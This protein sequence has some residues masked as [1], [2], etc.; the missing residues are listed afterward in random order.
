METDNEKL[1]EALERIDTL[2]RRVEALMRFCERRVGG[3]V[4]FTAVE[5][6]VRP[7]LLTDELRRKET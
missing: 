1:E 3:F 4:D 7:G 2:E 6:W 5:E